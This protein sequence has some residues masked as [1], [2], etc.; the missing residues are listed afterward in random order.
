MFLSWATPSTSGLQTRPHLPSATSLSPS[1]LTYPPFIKAQHNLEVIAIRSTTYALCANPALL[2]DVTSTSRILPYSLLTPRSLVGR[3]AEE[4]SPTHSLYSVVAI[5]SSLCP[6]IQT[7]E[8][9]WGKPK[10]SQHH[11]VSKYFIFWAAV[12]PSLFW[13]KR[14]CP[15]L[16]DS[17]FLLLPVSP[18][19]FLLLVPI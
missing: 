17:D 11:Q 15:S 7:T 9:S 18:F 3:V 12:A 4:G 8:A 14:C 10:P 5:T 2:Q 1:S 6:R 16:G 19:N 13:H